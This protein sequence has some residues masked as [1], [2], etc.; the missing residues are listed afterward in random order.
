MVIFGYDRLLGP[1]GPG[2]NLKKG[3][4]REKKLDV[5]PHGCTLTAPRRFDG[6][7]YKHDGLHEHDARNFGLPTIIFGCDT[8]PPTSCKDLARTSNQISGPST[9]TRLEA[10]YHNQKLSLE[11]QNCA[12]RV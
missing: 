5:G 9:K 6:G 10:M 1:L 12:H 3:P 8:Q 2:R 4:G 11:A 7:L